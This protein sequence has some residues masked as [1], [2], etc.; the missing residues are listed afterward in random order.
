MTPYTLHY[1]PDNASMII[2]L[3]LEELDVPYETR[4]VDRSKDA[5]RSAAFRTLNPVGRIPALE[6]PHGA[7][8][9]TAAIALW[10]ADT[11]RDGDRTLAPDVN[12]PDRGHFLSWLFFLSNTI[13]AEMRA[14]FY[15]ASMVGPD[16][17]AQTALRAQVQTNLTGH[18]DLLNTECDTKGALGQAEPT[19]CDLYTAALLR[20][21][22]LYPRDAD[23]RWY[24]LSRW[25]ALH[26]LAQRLETRQSALNLAK[27]EGL[28]PTPFSHP[29][30]PNP[31]EGSA[32]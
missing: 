26:A 7:M 13:H 32:I 14:L 23:R 30:P 10:L 20:W 18:L 25:R 2:R 27:A 21:L 29:Q 8:F 24:D 16:S 9:E 3:V 1:A 12:A 19:L 31:P 28:G 6:T 11:H 22:A 17:A 5:Q 15:P 4:L